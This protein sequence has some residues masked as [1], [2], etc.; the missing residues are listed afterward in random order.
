M[1]SDYIAVMSYINKKRPPWKVFFIPLLVANLMFA[2]SIVILILSGV[3]LWA[4]LEIPLWNIPL[5]FLILPIL[6]LIFSIAIIDCI[7]AYFYKRK[8]YIPMP[9]GI[10]DTVVTIVGIILS[11]I[12][13]YIISFLII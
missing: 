11:G 12:F 2:A 4:I 1:G 3:P 8:Q 13:I 10:F 5:S 9:Y 7:A 6:P